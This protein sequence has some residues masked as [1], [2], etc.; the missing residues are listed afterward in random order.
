[1]AA[2]DFSRAAA[3]ITAVPKGRWTAYKDV[4]AAGGN[5]RGAQAIGDWLRRRAM[6]FS[7]STG[8]YGPTGMY[9]THS[10]PRALECQPMRRRSE[11]CCEA[12]AL[13]SSLVDARPNTSVSPPTTGT[14]GRVAR[15]S[16]P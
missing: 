9:L 13:R 11:S 5:E 1:M 6:R 7:T 4:A 3:F 10:A 2:I 8:W 14:V 16:A 15:R 12:K